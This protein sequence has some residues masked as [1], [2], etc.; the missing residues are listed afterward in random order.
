[1]S[2]S[3]KTTGARRANEAWNMRG[4]LLKSEAIR[5]IGAW[6]KNEALT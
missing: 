3:G 4:L 2:E 5:L 6:R 1:M